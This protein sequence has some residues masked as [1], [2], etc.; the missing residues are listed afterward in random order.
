MND[1]TELLEKLAIEQH[2]YSFGSPTDQEIAGQQLASMALSHLRPMAEALAALPPPAAA[3]SAWGAGDAGEAARE[4]VR[5]VEALLAWQQ[6]TMTREQHA[7]WSCAVSATNSIAKAVAA[8][9][10]IS[11]AVG[12]ALSALAAPPAARPVPAAAL[13]PPAASVAPTKQ[14]GADG[15]FASHEE[16]GVLFQRVGG[17]RVRVDHNAGL[18]GTPRAAQ[19]LATALLTYLNGTPAAPAAAGPPEA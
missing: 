5:D 14:P 12:Y 10:K 18:G 9:A 16:K 7:E 13:A 3:S 17:L 15:W 11:P 8:L 19:A 6:G 2:A 4:L 1:Y